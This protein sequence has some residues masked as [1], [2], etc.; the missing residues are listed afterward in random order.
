MTDLFFRKATRAD[1][2]AIVAMLADDSLGAAR[3]DFSDPLP[4]VYLEAFAALD[5]DPNQLLAVVEAG[6]RIV[7]TLQL[8]F[9][10]GLS[11]RGAW[12]GLIESVRIA[13]GFRGQRLG[14]QMI[15]WAVEQCRERGCKLVQLTTDKSRVDAHRF[16][17]RLGFAASH[18]G[19]K[20]DLA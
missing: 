14:E 1:L 16:Y 8:S 4:A 3:E 10:P 12:R 11:R 15:R 6:G 5:R 18:I 7:G 17:D 19:Y 20:L 9:I 2:L 13:S